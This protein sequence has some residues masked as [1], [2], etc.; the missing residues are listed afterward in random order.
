MAALLAWRRRRAGWSAVF[1]ALAI[2][3]HQLALAFGLTLGILALLR[4]WRERSRQALIEALLLASS[5]IPFAA[6]VIV[7]HGVQPR[8]FA[9]TFPDIP[10]PHFSPP[11]LIFA[12]I[13]A[14]CWLEPLV[15]EWKRIIPVAL[16]TP[17]CAVLVCWSGIARPFGEKFME[18]AAGPVFSIIHAIS[19]LYTTAVVIAGALVA[20]GVFFF[21]YGASFEARLYVAS[22]IA[23]LL[24]VPFYFES[25]Y[26]LVICM[27]WP[28]MADVIVR[29]QSQVIIPLQCGYIFFGLAYAAVK[30]L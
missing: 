14:G 22:S 13:M 16:L 4:L 3:T 25:Y 26:A 1:L 21:L 24:N 18:G 8:L 30:L 10:Q 2:L 7:W 23:T 19:P 28:L 5:V 17:V 6:L 29:R 9:A 20:A 11:Q 27:A 12:L 15:A